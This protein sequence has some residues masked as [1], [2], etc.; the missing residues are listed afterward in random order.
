M[1]EDSCSSCSSCSVP[2]HLSTFGLLRPS[3]TTD[4]CRTT[5][6]ASSNAVM[7][8]ALDPWSSG[9]WPAGQAKWR[10]ARR[11]AVKR[12]LIIFDLENRGQMIQR[13]V[14]DPVD[15]NDRIER[16]SLALARIQRHL[17]G[18]ATGSWQPRRPGRRDVDKF[19]LRVDETLNEPWA[20]NAVDWGARASPI[21]P[22]R[23]GHVFPSR[24]MV[25]R[26]KFD[27]AFQIGRINPR[28]AERC[29]DALADFMPM[30][31]IGNH[32]TVL[33]QRLPPRLH[34]IRC[35]ADSRSNQ[36]FGPLESRDGPNIQHHR[37]RSRAKPGI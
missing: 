12:A 17:A 25:Q 20:R 2:T 8:S 11:I 23:L 30:N 36:V 14:L 24:E 32:R 3:A 27:F 1:L 37:R 10:R 6:N 21:C 18:H 34:F 28:R 26:S 13:G 22:R 7:L 4:L 35:A 16:A 15:A 33:L 29:R 19:R 31:A 5:M 9:I